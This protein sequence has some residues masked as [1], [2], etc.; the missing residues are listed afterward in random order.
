MDMNGQEK[1]VYKTKFIY[2]FDE[3]RFVNEVLLQSGGSSLLSYD[4]FPLLSS[5]EALREYDLSLVEAMKGITIPEGWSIVG[6]SGRQGRRISTV[7]GQ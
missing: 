2:F 3:K 6:S 5:P 1:P 7:D 4:P